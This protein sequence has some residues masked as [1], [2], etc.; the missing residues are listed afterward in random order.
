L[1]KSN[2]E[3]RTTLRQEERRLV[4]QAAAEGLELADE[5]RGGQAVSVDEAAEAMVAQEDGLALE[6]VLEGTLHDV[7]HAL[8]NLDAGTYGICD[9]CG[10]AIPAAR[11]EARPQATL[12]VRCKTKREHGQSTGQAGR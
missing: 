2:S 3:V 7:R 6:T 4:R 5:Q 10:Q 11:L 1:V 12:C 8:R 9:E